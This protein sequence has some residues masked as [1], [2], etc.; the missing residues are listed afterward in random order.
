MIS[1][2]NKFI[3]I[4]FKF[5]INYSFKNTAGFGILRIMLDQINK[6][7]NLDKLKSIYKD[8]FFIELNKHIELF[9]S[10]ENKKVI[11]FIHFLLKKLNIN[12]YKSQFKN[13]SLKRKNGGNFGNQTQTNIIVNLIFKYTQMV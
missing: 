13:F 3:T 5:N 9:V 6:Y 8:L 2:V 11:A 7:K 4:T 1:T 12:L 10:K